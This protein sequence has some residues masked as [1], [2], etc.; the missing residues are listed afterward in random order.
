MVR[1]VLDMADR[2]GV[3]T[4]SYLLGKQLEGLSL[5]LR[6][7]VAVVLVRH[8]ASESGSQMEDGEIK[9]KDGRNGIDQEMYLD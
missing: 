8:E 9:T 1:S 3:W 7:F 6:H 5:S 4:D 2:L